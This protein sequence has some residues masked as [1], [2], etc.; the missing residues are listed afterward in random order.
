MIKENIIKYLDL[1]TND[2]MF[3]IDLTNHLIFHNLF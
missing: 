3:H 2:L 1:S